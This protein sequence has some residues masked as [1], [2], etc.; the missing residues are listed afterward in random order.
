MQHLGLVVT[1]EQHRFGVR[2]RNILT[3][4]GKDVHTIVMSA[5]PIPRSLAMILYGGLA[6]S[7]IPELPSNRIPIKN[8]VVD[9]RY[10]PTTYKFMKD[11]IG[12]GRQVYV[13]CPM[14]EAGVMEELENVEE[15]SDKLR[16]VFDE[17]K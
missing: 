17:G 8:A 7:T 3:G 10:R 14:V 1:D 16:D 5:T 4:K 6:V 15:Y 12:K 13:I 2:Q 9:T 11:E